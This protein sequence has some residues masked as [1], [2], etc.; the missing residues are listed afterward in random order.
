MHAVDTHVL[1]RLITQDDAKQTAVAEALR[2][3]LAEPVLV[4]AAEP[5]D[6]LASCACALTLAWRWR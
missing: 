4:H 5:G 6:L 3:A 2:S 1:V